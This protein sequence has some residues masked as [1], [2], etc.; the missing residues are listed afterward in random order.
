MTPLMIKPLP[1]N[2]AFAASRSLGPNGWPVEPSPSHF[3]LRHISGLP[4]HYTQWLKCWNQR[5]R[6]PHG[7]G[8]HKRESSVRFFNPAWF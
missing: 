3:T 2:L 1:E 5:Q 8:D 7:R 6:W 4:L